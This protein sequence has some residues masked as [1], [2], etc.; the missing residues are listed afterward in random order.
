MFNE[1]PMMPPISREPFK[2][3]TESTSEQPI[4]AKLGRIN[5]ITA[6]PKMNKEETRPINLF[7]LLKTERRIPKTGNR[8]AINAT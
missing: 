3:K 2:F 6:P 8:I 5:I 4:E 7:F 1:P